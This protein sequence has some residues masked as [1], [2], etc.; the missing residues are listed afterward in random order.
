MSPS[1]LGKVVWR[2]VG[3]L[4]CCRRGF[5]SVVFDR[6]GGTDC[7]WTLS[8][9]FWML[10]GDSL[11]HLAS[12]EF[13]GPSRP[14]LAATLRPTRRGTLPAWSFR[15]PRGRLPDSLKGGRHHASPV[16]IGI[17]RT[18]RIGR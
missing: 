15:L 3:R 14:M 16:F 13:V 18:G 6:L 11:V 5:L 8:G 2:S 12:M 17:P 4:G 7:A 9:A 10:F 1:H